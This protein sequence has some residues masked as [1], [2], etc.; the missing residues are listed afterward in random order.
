MTAPARYELIGKDGDV[1]GPF[2]TAIEAWTYAQERPD[3]QAQDEE[4]LGF[5]CDMRV[6]GS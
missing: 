2:D 6:V 4:R 3:D 5:G 1:H